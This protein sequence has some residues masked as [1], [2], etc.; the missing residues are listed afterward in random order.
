MPALLLFFLTLSFAATPSNEQ[1]ELAKHFSK[2]AQLNFISGDSALIKPKTQLLINTIGTEL[3]AKAKASLHVLIT[4]TQGNRTSREQMI[5]NFASTLKM[6]Y[7]VIFFANADRKISFHKSPTFPFSVNEDAIF[8]IYIQDLLPNSKTIEEAQR[9]AIILSAYSQ[10]AY[11]IAQSAHVVLESNIVDRSGDEVLKIT[12]Y[13]VYAL[14]FF[15]FLVFLY[16]RL[17]GRR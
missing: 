9:S 12:R 14:V 10:I 16:I 7:F 3:N 4:N 17:K 15:T 2:G 13:I 8:R 11:E 1:A 5:E 6:P